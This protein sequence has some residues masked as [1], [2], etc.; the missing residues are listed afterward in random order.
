V[1]FLKTALLGAT[2]LIGAAAAANAADVYDRKGSFKDAPD[3]YLPAITWAGF[4]VGVQ[5][6][7][8]FDDL[9]EPSNSR[10]RS[11]EID[12]TFVG[13]IH[14]GYNWQTSPNWVFGIEGAVNLIADEIQFTDESKEQDLTSYLASI[15]GRVGYAAG[16]NLF[17]GTAGVAFLGYQD[18][19]GIDD[20]VGFVVGAGFERKITNNLSFGVEGL[21]YDFSS[22]YDSL[23]FDVERDFW[24]VQARLSYH[25][26]SG[27]NDESLK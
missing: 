6:G 1:K 11:Y 7:S 5:A 16:E 9:L 20:A 21:Y 22:E 15:R 3:A 13:G 19:T 12:S 17:Y 8:N 10:F 24:T 2:F 18:D 4:Y 27:G 14:L 23:D 26:N 25:F